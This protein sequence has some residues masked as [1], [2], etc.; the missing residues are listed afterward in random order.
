MQLAKVKKEETQI[1]QYMQ[2]LEILRNMSWHTTIYK[3][4]FFIVCGFH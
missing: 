3:R 1:E 2:K 4:T